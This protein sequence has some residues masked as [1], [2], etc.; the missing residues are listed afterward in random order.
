METRE[1]RR[2]WRGK[3]SEAL[4]DETEALDIEGAFRA[5]KTTICL[6]KEHSALKKHA[7]IH[8]LICRWT[9]DSTDSIL[10]PRWVE[11]LSEANEAVDWNGVEGYYEFLNGSRAYV[12]GLK[13]G[14]HTNRYAKFRGLTLSRVY[15]DQA[16]EVPDDIYLE[17]KARL[18][19]KGFP[20][21]IVISPNSVD[22]NHWIAKQ[23][24]VDNHIKHRKYISLSVYDNAHNLDADTI[25]NLEA[26]YPVTHAKHR[27]AILGL[28]GMNVIGI[29]VYGPLKEDAPETAAFQRFKHGLPFHERPL[30]Y[31]KHLPLYESIDFGK[32]HPCVV[33]AQ[34]TPYAELHVLGGLMGQNLFL[35]D[36][37]PIVQQHRAR[38]FPEALEVLTC[39]DPAGAHNNSQG[40]RNNGVKVL[41]DLG[42]AIRY[43]DDS[44]N[45]A[46]RAAMIERVAGYMR[47][48][49]PLG[50]AFGV[51]S[52]EDHWLRVAPEGAESYRFV[53][54]AMESGYVWDEHMV[55]V[56]SKQIRKPKK[57]G[58]YE[59]GMNCL[60][61][62]EHNFGGVQPTMEQAMR[63]ATAIREREQR[64][65]DY[66][67]DPY[68]AIRKANSGRGRRG[69]GRGGY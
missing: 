54:A 63:R 5:A 15:I 65:V 21:Q 2:I 17:L 23:F 10:K 26:T 45:P 62:L 25:R 28:R 32:H 9:D 29:P 12:R 38:L 40:L 44:N 42:F 19:Q 8:T 4:L 18:S 24:P 3:Q 55:S 39:C 58:H 49:S 68:D 37:G 31:N 1:F 33:W 6:W 66:D 52:A 14:E 53:A 61:Y 13:S 30:T 27:P 16:E 41:E 11:I 20:H 43:E 36:F 57:D 34:Y 64:R 56:G 7:G 22:D 46:V 47:R 59:H 60:E 48:R 67:R 51:N 50:E 69:F 35:E